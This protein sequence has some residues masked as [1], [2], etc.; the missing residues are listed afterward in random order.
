MNPRSARLFLDVRHGAPAPR[1]P[2]AFPRGRRQH[3]PAIRGG[4]AI[5]RRARFGGDLTP[6]DIAVYRRR[7]IIAHRVVDTSQV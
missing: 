6:G 1:A 5:H 4:E 2:G 7:G 3:A